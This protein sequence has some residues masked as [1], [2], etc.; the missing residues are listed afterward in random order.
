M[1]KDE[2]LNA[3]NQLLKA[4][5]LFRAKQFKKAGKNFHLAGNSYLK[6]NEFEIAHDCFIDG[7]KA[8][9]EWEKFDTSLELYRLAGQATL[10]DTN[11]MEANQ[12]YKEAINV[13]PNLRNSGDR[14]Y[15]YLLFSSLSYFCIFA[16]GQKE[17][18]LDYL[19]KIQK[20]VDSNYFKE[21]PLIRIITNL[22]LA[23]RDNDKRYLDKVKDIIQQFKFRDAELKLVKEILII[24]ESQI[25]LKTD[26]QLDKDLYTTND[27][28]NLTLNFNTD[29]L[30]NLSKESFYNFEF[31]EFNIVKISMDLSDNLA[32]SR[33]PNLPLSINLGKVLELGFVIKPH[34]QLD[35][36]YIGPV[37]FI[38]EINN[39]LTL[40]Y[41]TLSIKPNI[42]SPLPTLNISIRNMRPPLIGQTFPLEIL[43]ENQSSGEALDVKLDVDLPEEL[44][45]MR[46]TLNKQIYSL[47]SNEDLRWEI[48]LRPIEAGDYII[49]ISMN[50]KDQD[51]NLIEDIKEFPLIIK[52]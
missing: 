17:E 10:L 22:T 41:K 36:P 50:F 14:F 51:Q 23:I 49:K 3:Q 8:F 7:A 48:N 46:G 12:I 42:I 13:I 39:Y 35:N 1:G 18:G 15:N 33:K 26:L 21:N 20:K 5:K 2:R 19:K 34:F 29:S 11:Y 9:I 4:E 47:R 43:I 45:V 38:C 28:I 27:I 16:N 25:S 40:K 44:K 52:L 24:A 30:L 37:Y 32:L 6:L 31:K